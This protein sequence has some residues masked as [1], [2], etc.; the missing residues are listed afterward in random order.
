MKFKLGDKVR[1]VECGA[2]SGGHKDIKPAM[3][4]V[5]RAF[6]DVYPRWVGVDLGPG[7]DGHCLRQIGPDEILSRVLK[8]PTGWY[9]PESGVVHVR[10]KRNHGWIK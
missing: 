8:E 5:V 2:I 6:L 1:V 10:A 9:F 4:G 7:F 3:L